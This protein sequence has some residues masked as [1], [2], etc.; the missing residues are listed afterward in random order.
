MRRLRTTSLSA[1]LLGAALSLAALTPAP[2]R[3]A[4]IS[5]ADAN[6][7]V[8]AGKLKLIDIRRPE[9]WRQT[10][11]AKGASRI[12]MQHPGGAR[13]FLDD[14]LK[15]VNGDRNAPIALICRTGNRTTVVENFLRQQGFTQVYNIRE[16]MAGSA[17]GPGW[18]RRGL[19]VE[20]C[21]RC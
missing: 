11:V 5:A 13:G 7:Q 16:G 18:M 20:D 6:A 2:V 17:A 15:Q 9:E 10:G 8:Q 14:V 12:D 21:S 4:D 19:P 3:A 1:A